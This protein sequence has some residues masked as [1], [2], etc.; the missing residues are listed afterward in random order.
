MIVKNL[1]EEMCGRLPLKSKGF[2]IR[3]LHF[4][5]DDYEKKK[6]IFFYYRNPAEN[7]VDSLDF[8]LNFCSK[9]LKK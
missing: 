1:C 6:I 7:Q 5:V 9:K 3:F 2:F 8:P 4:S